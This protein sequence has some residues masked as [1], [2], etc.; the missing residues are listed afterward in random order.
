M[1]TEV[2]VIGAG[3]AGVRAAVSAR[4]YGVD[5]ILVALDQ[6]GRSGSTFSNISKGWGIQALV[7]EERTTDSLENFYEDII[8]VGLGCGREKLIRILVE[9]SGSC[10]ED[11]LAW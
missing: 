2:L 10:L 3:A 8:Q 11:L 1:K 6:V 9:E 5:T 4:K 7:G